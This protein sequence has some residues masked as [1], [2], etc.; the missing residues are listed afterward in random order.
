[1]LLISSNFQL[2]YLIQRE[3]IYVLQSLLTQHRLLQ[4]I[5]KEKKASKQARKKNGEQKAERTSLLYLFEITRLA[6]ETGYYDCELE[7]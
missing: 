7:E 2:H 1:M 3:A 6:Y 4:G 5:N